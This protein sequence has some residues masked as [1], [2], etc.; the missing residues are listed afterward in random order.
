MAMCGAIES[1]SNF[2]GPNSLFMK[3]S[4]KR[5]G[6]LLKNTNGQTSVQTPGVLKKRTI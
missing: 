4:Q 6:T 1:I 2:G 3:N 5:F